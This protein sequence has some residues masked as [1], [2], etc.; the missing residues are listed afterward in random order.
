[1][2]RED[3]KFTAN[4]ERM[5][6][7][8]TPDGVRDIYGEECEAKLAL[9]DGIRHIF[10]SYGFQDIQTP[11]FE[12][13]DVF[14][15]EKGTVLS[16]EMYKFFDRDNN[17][18]VLRPDITPSIARCVAKYQREEE[19]Q[20][21]LCYMAQTYVN[22]ISYQGKL[23]ET[24]QAGA[25]LVNDDSSDADAEMLALGIECL[26][27][28][29][30]KE[31][32]MSVGHA[33]FFEGIAEEAGC[34]PE[35][36]EEL[37]FLLSSKNFFGAEELLARKKLGKPFLE[38]IQRLP[39]LFGDMEQ[40]SYV[41]ERTA[42]KKVLKAIDRLEKVYDIL[43]TYGFEKYVTFDLSM[44]SKYTYYTGVI[45]KGYTY[46]NGDAIASGGRYD[47]LVEQYGKK[48]S[49]IGVAIVID[50]LMTALMR[51]KLLPEKKSDTVLIV[52]HPEKRKEAIEKAEA[53]RREG[54]S[55]Q[56]MR[57]SSRRTKK[58][59]EAYCKRTGLNEMLCL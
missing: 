3:Y 56:L 10:K 49:A 20:I 19:M 4:Y 46:G 35:E 51:Q 59:Y 8:H 53:L 14:S 33:G 6:L 1:M 52:Y 34:S 23:K 45:F 54:K 13:F 43:C 15:K 30:L 16:R 37:R 31:F 24:T 17:T 9:Q 55:I 58:D 39:E 44:I 22:N 40:L 11:S 25:E 57:K 38:I 42:N 18:L 41:K 50:H 2:S 47:N 7:L 26:L 12:F 27:E 29:G 21:R 48:A 32:Q 36:K 28:S 5:D